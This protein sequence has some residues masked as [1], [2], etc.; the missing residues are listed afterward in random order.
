MPLKSCGSE[1]EQMVPGPSSQMGDR[2]RQ[3]PR[4][5]LPWTMSKY[6]NSTHRERAASPRFSRNELIAHDVY[7]TPLIKTGPGGIG[8]MFYDL[9]VDTRLR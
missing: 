8:R 7:D 1:V 6:A 3:A 5:D 2:V 9:D 4:S